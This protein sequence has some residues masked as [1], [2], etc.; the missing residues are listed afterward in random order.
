MF[1]G[2]GGVVP[3]GTCGQIKSAERD[4]R[5]FAAE[6]HVDGAADDVGS[7]ERR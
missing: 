6:D 2:D 4:R 7:G 5:T 1:D 3:L